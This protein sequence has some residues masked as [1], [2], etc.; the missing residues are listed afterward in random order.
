MQKKIAAMG[1][2]LLNLLRFDFASNCAR[3]IASFDAIVRKW[4][5]QKKTRVGIMYV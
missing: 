2:P 3:V 5:E 4:V 1:V